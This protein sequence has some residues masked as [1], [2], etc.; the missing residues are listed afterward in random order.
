MEQTI[1]T[2]YEILR[3]LTPDSLKKID[4]AEEPLRVV[5]LMNEAR[6]LERG[7]ALIHQ[8]TVFFDDRGHDWQWE[9][10]KLRYFARA[11]VCDVLVVYEEQV[12]EREPE[13]NFCP[14]CGVKLAENPGHACR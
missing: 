3:D 2:R 9:N 5:T 13:M 14:H 12:V 6:F 11:T 1:A 10:G 7:G 4:V 8:S